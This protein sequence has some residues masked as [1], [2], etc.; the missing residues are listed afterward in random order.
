MSEWGAVKLGDVLALDIES[1]DVVKTDEYPIVG[2]LNRGRGLLYRDPIQG[3]E[4]A[5]KSLNV[6]RPKRV[7]Y[8]RLKAFEGA[9]TVTPNDMHI[10]YASAEFPTFRCQPELLPEYF[11]LVTTNPS[12]WD[13]LQNLS[14]GMG[15][16]RERVK[17]STF[18]TIELKLPSLPEQRRIVAVMSTV[19]EQITALE[20]E[21]DAARTVLD[22]VVSTMFNAL[23]T[24]VKYGSVAT[25]RSGPSWGAAD[26]SKTVVDDGI[27]VIK[28]TNTKSDGLLDMSDETYV[29]GL[30]ESTARLSDASLIIIRTNG[31]RDRIGNVFRP[32]REALGCAVS[33]FQFVS[34][35]V[36]PADRD[37]LYWALRESSMQRMMTQAASGTTG[38]GNLAVNWLNA[39]EI[40]WT[41]DV[42]KRAAIIAACDAAEVVI[43]SL[44]AELTALHRVRADLLTALLSQAITVDEAVDQFLQ[45]A[46]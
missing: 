6:I 1:V 38:L 22:R 24:T 5:Y 2:V 15:G 13:T 31:N 19:D 44:A 27:R 43:T 11:A 32:S 41:D 26:E 4:T 25:T 34:Q 29:V 8:S 40:P 45:G 7:V 20:A 17:P 18:L 33:A 46:A 28:T 39:A 16:R 30:P 21:I 37:F 36:Q 35:A 42:D 23:P 12:L 14:T 10:A 3:T 9:I